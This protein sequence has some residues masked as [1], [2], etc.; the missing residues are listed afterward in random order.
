M[1]ATSEA[2][3]LAQHAFFYACLLHAGITRLHEEEG[4]LWP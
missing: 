3:H 1:F 2:L 4:A